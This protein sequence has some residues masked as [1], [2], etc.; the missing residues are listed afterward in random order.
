MCFKTVDLAGER[1]IAKWDLGAV[2][3]RGAVTILVSYAGLHKEI[4]AH[5]Q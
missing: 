2:M 3:I 4:C 5:F 1:E